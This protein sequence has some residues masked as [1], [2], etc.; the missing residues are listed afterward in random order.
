[1]GRGLLPNP[2]ILRGENFIWSNKKCL[3]KY[4]RKEGF[5]K[6]RNKIFLGNHLRE[7]KDEVHR[8][9]SYKWLLWVVLNFNF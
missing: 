7:R 8:F 3:A 6:S 2:Q 9:L 1:L 4:L 5:S